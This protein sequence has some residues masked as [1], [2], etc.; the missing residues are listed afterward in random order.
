M[1]F[2]LIFLTLCTLFLKLLRV[3]ERCIYRRREERF[4][5]HADSPASCS[6]EDMFYYVYAF[7]D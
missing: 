4:K 5:Q 2:F 3:V 6:V 1:K 7:A